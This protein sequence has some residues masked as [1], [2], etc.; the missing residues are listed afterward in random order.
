MRAAGRKQGAP[1]RCPSGEREP[2]DRQ[3]WPFHFSVCSPSRSSHAISVTAPPNTA[4]PLPARCP[5]ITAR[6]GAGLR[7]RRY[8]GRPCCSAAPVLGRVRTGAASPRAVVPRDTRRPGAVRASTR[9]TGREGGPDSPPVVFA[10][11]WAGGHA[12]W[13]FSG[14]GAWQCAA[15][16]CQP[17]LQCGRA[18]QHGRFSERHGQSGLHQAPSAPRPVPVPYFLRR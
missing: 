2:P 5:P 6:G 9:G 12:R 3:P 7:G 8:S 18:S 13:C 15:L 10:C 14:A 4:P 1:R 17:A 16:Q 11:G